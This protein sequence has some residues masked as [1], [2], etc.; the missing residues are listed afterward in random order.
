MSGFTDRQRFDFVNSLDFSQVEDYMRETDIDNP[1][2]ERAWCDA[3]MLAAGL[4]PEPAPTIEELGDLYSNAFSAHLNQGWPYS[5]D[6][7]IRVVARQLEASGGRIAPENLAKK[8]GE[9]KA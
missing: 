6:A 5:R 1:D 2:V 4:V 9:N 7:G 8:E 3:A